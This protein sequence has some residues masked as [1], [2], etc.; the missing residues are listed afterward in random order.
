M[1]KE[2]TGIVWQRAEIASPCVK[3]CAIHPS[4]N[5]CTGCY[6]TVDEITQWSSLSDDKRAELMQELPD[7]EGLL[8]KRRGGRRARRA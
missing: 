1:R 4:A 7:R 5:I 2:D 3:L 6:R 8:K